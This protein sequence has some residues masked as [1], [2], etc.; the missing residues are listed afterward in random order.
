MRVPE[1]E[2]REKGAEKSL[3][4]IVAESISN[5]LKNTDL[6]IQGVQRTSE[7]I[8]ARKS[9]NEHNIVKILKVKDKEKIFRALRKTRSYLKGNPDNNNS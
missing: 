3:E 9:T 2:G 6:Y 5:L 1:E 7:R 4:E 8:N